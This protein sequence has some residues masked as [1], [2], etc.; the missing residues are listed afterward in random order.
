[1]RSIA[2][3]TAVI[4]LILSFLF[5]LFATYFAIQFFVSLPGQ[6]KIKAIRFLSLPALLAA[7]VFLA[8]YF[9][10]RN[11]TC[12]FCHDENR[13]EKP[14]SKISCVKCHKQGGLSGEFLFKISQARMFFSFKKYRNGMS[15]AFLS[16]STCL[17]CHEEIYELIALIGTVERYIISR[18]WRARDNLICASSSVTRLSLIAGKYV[19]KDDPVLIVRAQHGLPAVGEILAPFMHAYLVAGWMRGSHWGPLMPVSLKDAKC[20]LFDGPPRVVAL[21]FQ[22]ANGAIAEDD[23]GKPMIADLFADPAFDYARKETLQLAVM[24]RHMGEFEPARLSIE[25]ME[26]TTL[27]Q[28]LEKLRN[29]F[30]PLEG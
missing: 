17:K 24:M 13:L 30:R 29:R 28:V 3:E 6:S 21:G 26:Y 9:T 8:S 16:P 23:E 14:H 11:E 27:P 19:G 1:M 22:V 20:T 2:P 4:F 25:S 10:D 7:I 15:A 5:L 12:I 18:V